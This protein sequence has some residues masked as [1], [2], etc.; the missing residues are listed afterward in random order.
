MSLRRFY[1]DNELSAPNTGS[2]A[3]RIAA[4]LEKTSGQGSWA[5]RAVEDIN[6]E[7]DLGPGSWRTKLR[8][9]I[10][11][12]LL[13]EGDSTPAR[14]TEAVDTRITEAGDRR[15]LEGL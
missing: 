9:A 11:L 13:A 15:I 6:E 12:E 8:R 4:G 5:R 1:R 3:R 14:I 2:W 7:N 10:A